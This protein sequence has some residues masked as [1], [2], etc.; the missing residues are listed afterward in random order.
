MRKRSMLI[1]EKGRDEKYQ[2]SLWGVSTRASRPPE[3][4]D[5]I[6]V[7]SL[8]HFGIF[9]KSAKDCS[10]ANRKNGHSQEKR[11]DKMVKRRSKCQRPETT[12]NEVRNA[13]LCLKHQLRTCVH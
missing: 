2:T 6:Y 9:S 11:A 10:R 5:L 4:F 3:Q 8:N 12:G 7:A 13:A 1:E